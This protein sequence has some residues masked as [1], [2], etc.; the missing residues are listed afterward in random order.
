MGLLG[1]PGCTLW[2]SFE[3]QLTR[4]LTS[5]GATRFLIPVPSNVPKGLK[6]YNQVYVLNRSTNKIMFSN[7]AAGST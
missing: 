4:V 7:A 5:G 6:F 3:F 2:S 1:F